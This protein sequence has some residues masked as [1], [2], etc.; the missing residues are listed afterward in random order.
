MATERRT[1]DEDDDELA[2][3]V[4]QYALGSLTLGQAAARADVSRWRMA[5]ILQKAGVELRV[6]PEDEAA[7]EAEVDTALD[8]E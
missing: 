5:E 7:A 3:I 4:G 1:P 2:L 8:M 6:G